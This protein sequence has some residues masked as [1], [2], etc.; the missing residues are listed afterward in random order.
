MVSYFQAHAEEFYRALAILVITV[1][2]ARLTSYFIKKSIYTL[3]KK[4]GKEIPPS[5]YTRLKVLIHLIVILIYFLGIFSALYQFEA[6]SRLA[7]T[8]FASA[9]VIG[10]FLGIAAQSTLGSVVSSFILSISQPFRLG[11]EIEI[12]GKRGI[13]KEITL[14]YTRIKLPEGSILVVP[15]KK[16]TEANLINHSWEKK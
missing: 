15:N 12:E 1:L 16:L 5:E 9:G 10:I 3:T 4:L 13:V 6:I 7:A 8:L 14:F 11:D 2:V